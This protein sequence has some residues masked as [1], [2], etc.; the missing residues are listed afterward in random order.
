[1]LGDHDRT[2][3]VGGVTG[4]RGDYEP[5][6]RQHTRRDDRDV[7]RR[8]MTNAQPESLPVVGVDIGGSGIKAAPVDRAR[9]ALTGE[10]VRLLT[11]APAT[12][13]SVADVVTQVLAQLGVPGPVGLTLPAVV[14]A[15]V[16][17]TAANI[18]PTWIGVAAVELFATATGR[19]VA[20]INDADAAGI[21]EIRFGAGVDRAGVV[22]LITLGTGIGSALFVDGMLVPNTEFGHLP[23][24]HEDAEDWAAASVRDH[25]ELSWKKWAARLQSYL[26]LVERLLW[27]DLFI[28]GGGVSKHADKFLPYIDLRTEIVPAQLHNDAGIVGAALVSPVPEETH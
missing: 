18:D 28:V 8:A 4:F 16:V 6:A 17:E 12:P 21:A 14:R 24:H 13:T 23:L 10:R 7:G 9:G 15:G 22:V 11:P 1:M 27:P 20:V 26:S 5:P 2:S 19:S 3:T 25:D